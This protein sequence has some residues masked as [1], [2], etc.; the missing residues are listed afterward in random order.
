MSSIRDAI[1]EFGELERTAKR[2][3]W[4][5]QIHPLVML[6]LTVLFIGITVSFPKYDL[7]GILDMGM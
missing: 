4:V 6:F 5:N 2:D 3:Q 7:I 1:S